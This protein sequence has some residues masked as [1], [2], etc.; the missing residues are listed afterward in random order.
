MRVSADALTAALEDL[1]GLLFQT[2]LVSAYES[3]LVANR[4]AAS[5]VS[6]PTIADVNAAVDWLFGFLPEHPT[7]RLFPFRWDWK[8]SE[9]SGR[10]TV[11]NNTTRGQ[12]NLACSLFTNGDLRNGLTP[13]AAQTLASA[14]AGLTERLP[15]KQSLICLVLRGH[16]FS[17]GESWPEAEHELLSALGMSQGELDAITSPVSLGVDLLADQ[18]WAADLLPE[19]LLPH[20]LVQITTSPP[21]PTAPTV[22]TPIAI[23]DRTERMLRRSVARYPCVLLVGPPGT[24]KGTLVKWITQQ[25]AAGPEGCGFPAGTNPAPLWSTPDDSWNSFRLIGGLAPRADGNLAWS[26]GVLLNSLA[27]NRWLVLDEVNRADMDKIMGPLLTWLSLQD[28]EIGRTAAHEGEPINL[29]WSTEHSSS[30]DEETADGIPTRYRAGTTWRL[31][32]TYNPQDAGR[33]FRL[34]IALSRRFVVVPVGPLSSGQFEHLLGGIEPDL[35]EDYAQAIAGLYRSHKDDHST[36]LGPAVFLRIAKYLTGKDTF[37]PELLAEAYVLGVGKYLAAYD[38]TVWQKLNLRVVED[39]EVLDQV[40][41]D[42]ISAQRDIL[43]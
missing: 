40:A 14:A 32:G 20:T 27:E 26:P 16:A 35:A 37:D 36:T 24:G 22:S 21:G 8:E 41:W 43:G 12:K 23:D 38:D 33:V 2:K 5:G 10:K 11:W 30:A 19:A 9:Q 39:E 29:G 28:V 42:W 7:G 34:G 6:A 25:V 1:K 18:E 4:L 3:F 13:N 17:P 15:S 31:I